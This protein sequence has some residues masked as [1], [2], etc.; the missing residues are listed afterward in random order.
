MGDGRTS[1]FK[2]HNFR[3]YCEL[4]LAMPFLVPDPDCSPERRRQRPG[5][6]STPGR[7][8]LDWEVSFSSRLRYRPKQPIEVC[9]RLV[10]SKPTHLLRSAT[11]PLGKFYSV[12]CQQNI[13]LRPSLPLTNVGGLGDVGKIPGKLLDKRGII[14]H[15]NEL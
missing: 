4:H 1:R 14:T 13:K 5:V 15:Y 10:I 12:F 7:V 3:T 9:R 8:N 11:R 6:T 2:P